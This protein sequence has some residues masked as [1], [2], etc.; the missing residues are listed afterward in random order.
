[1]K[2][3]PLREGG[4]HLSAILEQYDFVLLDV[5]ECRIVGKTFAE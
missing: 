3:A 2:Y 4:G 1:M 5:S